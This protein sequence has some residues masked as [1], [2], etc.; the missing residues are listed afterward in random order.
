MTAEV[1]ENN[2]VSGLGWTVI[3]GPRAD[4][5]RA[6]GQTH[7]DSIRSAHQRSDGWQALLRGAAGPARDRVQQV[8]DSS[9]RRLPTE[10][11]EIG[12]LATGAGLDERDLWVW[13]LR[14]DLGSD[15]SGCSDLSAVIDDQV[16]LGHNE[17]GAAELADGIRLVTLIIDGDPSCTAVWYPGMLPAN[18]FVATSAGLVFGMDHVPVATARTDGVGR[19]LLTRHAQRQ[20]TGAAARQVLASLTCAGGFACDIADRD[21]RRTDLVE[22]AAG[23]VAT[24][25]GE[26]VRHTNHLRLLDGLQDGLRMPDSSIRESRQR[27]RELAAASA[28]PRSAGEVFAALRNPEVCGRSSDRW[29]FST[30]VA[31]LTA[32]RI[33]VQGTGEPWRGSL[34]A[35]AAGVR[36][37]V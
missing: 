16:L 4:V 5:F 35:F 15:G 8:I 1:T 34:S 3:R 32:D 20:P 13:N 33:T 30:A 36:E 28:N 31:E 27:Y 19:H 12:W 22:T 26:T 10:A 21:G 9:R 14:G 6:L 24:G 11:A 25:S 17:D 18:S 23:R 29:T 7:A 37:P 2:P